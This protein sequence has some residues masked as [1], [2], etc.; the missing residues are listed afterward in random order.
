MCIWLGINFGVQR[1]SFTNILEEIK[2]YT[3][4][5]LGI[6]CVQL[7]VWYEDYVRVQWRANLSR[8]CTIQKPV[9][10]MRWF[11][12]NSAGLRSG[13]EW[14]SFCG[15][16]QG[17]LIAYFEGPVRSFC[18]EPGNRLKGDI[19]LCQLHTWGGPIVL[20][21][22]LAQ[23]LTMLCWVTVQAGRFSIHK[24]SEHVIRRKTIIMLSMKN[25]STSV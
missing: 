4:W 16:C 3:C 23:V 6:F 15:Y 17:F 10:A 1:I 2:S 20:Q 18:T 24:L 12:F 5:H 22:I 19:S 9:K 7:P 8:N 14:L 21:R 13:L 11:L 25:M